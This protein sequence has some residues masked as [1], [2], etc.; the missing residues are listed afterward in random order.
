M[1]HF[2]LKRPSLTL[3]I[4]DLLRGHK[5]LSTNIIEQFF[6]SF[7]PFF[8]MVLDRDLLFFLAL[9]RN[10]LKIFLD[11]KLLQTEILHVIIYAEFCVEFPYSGE[12]FHSTL[13]AM[14]GPFTRFVSLCFPIFEIIKPFSQ[15][16]SVIHFAIRSPITIF[17]LAIVFEVLDYEVYFIFVQR[18]HINNI[19]NM[20]SPL[21]FKLC[22]NLI[23]LIVQI[24]VQRSKGL[25]KIWIDFQNLC[26]LLRHHIRVAVPWILLQDADGAQNTTTRH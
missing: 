8:N 9:P 21:N 14:K 16:I 4:M 2:L 12:P 18:S 19:V 25:Y 10:N 24:W 26:G 11:L 15:P 3:N 6:R 22:R 13:E 7:S 23:K 20:W 17:P 5:R 1:Y